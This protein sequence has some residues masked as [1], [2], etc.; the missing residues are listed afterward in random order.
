MRN[1]FRCMR[2]LFI[3]VSVFFSTLSF[4]QGFIDLSSS[5]ETSPWSPDGALTKTFSNV[6]TPPITVTATVEGFTNRFNNN[7]PRT[8][9]RGLWFSMNLATRLQAVTINFTFSEPVTNLS[10]GV[11]GIDREQS[12][13]NYQDRI[14]IEGY[15]DKGAGVTPNVSY[16][17]NFAFLTDGTA[18]Y[19]KV[20]SGFNADP[21]DST[22]TTVNFRNSGV[23]KLTITYGSGR[24]IRNGS[25]TTQGI[26]LTGLSWS[27]II[28]VQLIY[29]RGK[30]EAD[31]VRLNWATATEI[32]SAYFNVERSV[33]LKEFTAIGKI[34]SAGDSRQRIEY[35]FLD[36]APLP[37]VNYYRLKQ[38]DKDET[39]E[40]SKIIAVSPYTE[41]SQFVVYPNPSDGQDIKL[42][43]NNLELDGL[44]LVTMLGQDI[45]FDIQAG[46]TNSLMIHPQRTLEN[47]LYF[48]TYLT[49]DRGR[50]TQK[51]WVNR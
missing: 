44:R 32:N 6:G 50:V 19:I 28:P 40:L 17:P 37:G 9:S 51:L 23:K 8:D 33:D 45:P 29:F 22:R 34:T 49:P 39:S 1:C 36:E 24:D 18:P 47:G 4:G 7:T 10:F 15:D 13:S 30:S 3:I 42:Q 27:N 11:L 31:R 20:I 5:N 25:L 38:V 12:F 46:S 48:V 21:F 14:A 41:A 16:N 35:S 43:F 26:F 2:G